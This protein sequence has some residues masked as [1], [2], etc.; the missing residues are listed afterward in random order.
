MKT[1]NADSVLIE[2]EDSVLFEIE[3]SVLFEFAD[4]VLLSL[5]MGD[6]SHL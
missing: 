1:W 5:F 3:D 2:I 4:S 6:E